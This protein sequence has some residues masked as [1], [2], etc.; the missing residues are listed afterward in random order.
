[1]FAILNYFAEVMIQALCVYENDEKALMFIIWDGQH[2]A[3]VLYILIV[4]VFG[5]SIDNIEL[6]VNISSSKQKLEIRR[7]HILLNGSAKKSF[8]P[9]DYFQQHLYG[10][11]VDGSKDPYWLDSA[12]IN[13][14]F[15]DAGIFV[16]NKN[17]GDEKEIG[18]YT[19]LAGTIWNKHLDKRKPVE[20]TKLFCDYWK[21][22]GHQ[23]SVDAKE[24]RLL[25]EFF[26]TCYKEKCKVNEQW[27]SEFVSVCRSLFNLD[28][29]EN[30]PFWAKVSLAYDTWYEKTNPEAFKE[31]GVKGYAPEPNL[32][33]PFLIEQL[34]KS[35][36]LKTPVYI[37]SKGFYVKRESL[38]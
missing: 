26:Y 3:L 31:Y 28:F 33:I 8:E 4:Y 37:S 16:T 12:S 24:A 36:K 23:R 25:Y 15:E 7:N 9:I 27:M 34:K 11:K 18:A 35:S 13:D 10:V 32:G 2:T 1:V 17:F 20:V 38:F 14:L 21:I 29:S 22:S 19:M 6:P 30:S 5:E